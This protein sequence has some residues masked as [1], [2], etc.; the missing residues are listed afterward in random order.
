MQDYLDTD[1]SSSDEDI[2][3]GHVTVSSTATA[4]AQ[5]GAFADTDWPRFDDEDISFSRVT[6]SLEELIKTNA[7]Q[8]NSL[9]AAL[10]RLSGAIETLNPQPQSNDKK[11]AF[12]TA[13]QTLA[14]EFDQELKRKYGNDLDT[15]LIFAG[16]FSA[17]TS[18][19][20]IQIQPEFQPDPTQALLTILV[21]NMTGTAVPGQAS[22]QAGPATIIVVAQSL[23][24]S[25]LFST[26]L[27]ALLAMLAKQWLLHYDSVGKRGTIEERGL[28][29][30]RKLD[31]LHRWKFDP[32]M[33]LF[34]L[35][36]QLS[37]FLFATALSVYLW[38]VHY[39]IAAI[40]F[41]L[42]SVGCVLYTMM[43][44]S[45]L[46]SPDSPFQTSLTA[47]L[48]ALFSVGLIPK[49]L[50]TLA[51]TSQARVHGAI[52]T[53]FRPFLRTLT[54]TSQARVRGAI[55]TLFRPFLLAY[56]GLTRT[57]RPLLPQFCATEGD[58]E[59]SSGIRIFD[60]PE[61]SQQTAA[62][63]WALE[64]STEPRVVEAAAAMV[65]DLQWPVGVDLRPSLRRL[66]ETFH[67]C[68]D[69]Q[70]VCPGMGYRATSCVKAIG[71]L[72]IVTKK[73][74][75]EDARWRNL[76]SDWSHLLSRPS[77][78][79]VI[80]FA[81][82]SELDSD[83]LSWKLRLISAQANHCRVFG[84]EHFLEWFC[85]DKT[86]LSD[87]SLCAEF[88]FCVNS[89]FACPNANDLTLMNKR[90]Y[91]VTLTQ[92]LFENL[93]NPNTPF[94]H[95]WPGTYTA[96]KI[97]DW[98]TAFKENLADQYRP[99]I[100]YSCRKA[101]YKLC[102]AFDPSVAI[103]ILQLVRLD[104]KDFYVLDVEKKHIQDVSWVYRALEAFDVPEPSDVNIIGDL[105]QVLFDYGPVLPIPTTAC[106]QTILL[107]ISFGIHNGR[108]RILALNILCS[109]SHWFQDNELRPILQKHMVWKTLG[110]LCYAQ[111]KA[112]FSRT[113]LI[114]EIASYIDLGNKISEIQEWTV[115][116]SEDLTAW[117][118]HLSYM[119]HLSGDVHSRKA[120]EGE[121][122]GDQKPLAMAF[123]A[124]AMAWGQYKFSS[125]QDLHRLLP[126]IGCTISTAFS[127]RLVKTEW[128]ATVNPTQRFKDVV[129]V[130]L[131]D[132]VM[133]AAASLRAN[134]A[135]ANDMQDVDHEL[136]KK[137]V[138]KAIDLLSRL[139]STIHNELTNGLPEESTC[140]A[141]ELEKWEGL[142]QVFHG[143]LES[144]VKFMKR[145]EV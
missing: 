16:L 121:Q 117:L 43:V 107:G 81:R 124:L 17:V 106:L 73:Q 113:A 138:D 55:T 126:L 19:F 82:I 32:I 27:S 23:L 127:A 30:Q 28:E 132:T 142:Q 119:S 60:V 90:E 92:V 58:V 50:R 57:V 131:A 130:G 62:V 83:K 34:P 52:V 38:T 85:P 100:R 97:V 21:Q 11:T 136:L 76:A 48:R 68:L 145:L 125:P 25:S 118:S 36:L 74:V 35:L 46:V 3:F 18:A 56:S 109:A 64:T 86:S 15:S 10:E 37:F 40:V 65:S 6:V 67:G 47:L 114:K 139:V 2:P 137:F 61:P 29:R 80:A 14:D 71:L 129:M 128:M 88:L 54:C 53:L 66:M 122:F 102:A 91:C 13:Y 4:S 87:P 105:L 42:T 70:N 77:G 110:A 143:D 116:V 89:F 44:F 98:I 93:A 26:L 123:T 141:T 49:S 51:C 133:L 103:S 31:G 12:W 79:S 45:A 135:R 108:M 33:Q 111:S 8:S 1:R 99:A 84:V 75:E 134:T 72:R 94:G 59:L 140:W 144:L 112:N 5:T 78:S 22:P 7:E 96:Q 39:V 95:Y 24:Y 115:T 69:G 63:Q 101:A 20:I 9:R 104:W 41:G 120:R